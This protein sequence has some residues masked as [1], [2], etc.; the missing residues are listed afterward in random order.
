MTYLLFF[1]LYFQQDTAQYL[2]AI[3]DTGF[4]GTVSIELE[5]SPEPGRMEEL[6]AEAYRGAAAIMADVGVRTAAPVRL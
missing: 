5:R 2:Q 3:V 1:L 6:V 4:A